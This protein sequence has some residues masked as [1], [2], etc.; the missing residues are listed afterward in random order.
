MPPN[1]EV[2]AILIALFILLLISLAVLFFKR[3]REVMKES[4]GVAGKL[5]DISIPMPPTKV[6]A[7]LT[8]EQILQS[9]QPPIIVVSQP[10]SPASIQPAYP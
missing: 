10:A 9:K 7:E 4:E 2:I 3:K 8:P 5:A 1:T 6:E